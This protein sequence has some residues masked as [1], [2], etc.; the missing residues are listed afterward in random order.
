MLSRSLTLTGSQY[1]TITDMVTEGWGIN[2]PHF[3]QDGARAFLKINEKIGG[4][5]GSSTSSEK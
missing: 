2:A 5:G 3:C 1:K 4:G